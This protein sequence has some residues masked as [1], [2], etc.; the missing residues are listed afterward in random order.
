MLQSDY[1]SLGSLITRQRHYRHTYTLVGR[2]ILHD[3]GW[4]GEKGRTTSPYMNLGWTTYVSGNLR[5]KWHPSSD[6]L[7]VSTIVY[8]QLRMYGCY[9]QYVSI[10]PNSGQPKQRLSTCTSIKARNVRPGLE[11]ACWYV[12]HSL[13]GVV[14]LGLSSTMRVSYMYG[15]LSLSWIYRWPD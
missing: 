11:V 14:G 9:I 4:G 5:L 15:T 6:I 12:G 10:K 1:L 2:P 8:P 3:D 13:P 7:L